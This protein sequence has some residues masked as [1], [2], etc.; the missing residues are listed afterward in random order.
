[1]D[2]SCATKRIYHRSVTGRYCGTATTHAAHCTSLL[3][4]CL[5]LHTIAGRSASA[6]PQVSDLRAETVAGSLRNSQAK[7]KGVPPPGVFRE[8]PRFSAITCRYCSPA[9]GIMGNGLGAGSFQD[10]CACGLH[11]AG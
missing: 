3:R 7:C 2:L 11:L 10:Q 5:L 4:V 8:F 1:M 9:V 6:P